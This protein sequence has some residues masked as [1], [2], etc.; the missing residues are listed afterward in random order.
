MNKSWALVSFQDKE[1]VERVLAAHAE[2]PIKAGRT[3]LKLS[4][5]SYDTVAHSSRAMAATA[6]QQLLKEMADVL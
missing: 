4:H 3:A 2:Q 6:A 5:M 1:T